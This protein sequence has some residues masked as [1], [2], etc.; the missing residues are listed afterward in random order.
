VGYPQAGPA[1][2]DADNKSAIAIASNPEYHARTK[3]IDIQYHFVSE[4]T[5]DGTVAFNYVPTAEMAADGLTKALER[6]KFE[7]WVALVSLHKH[8]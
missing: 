3:H 4:K 6:V 5:S 1:I 2:I 7:R 8:E